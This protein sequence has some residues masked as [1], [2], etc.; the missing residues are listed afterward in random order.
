M[1]D[2]RI[3]GQRGAAR[4]ELLPTQLV[5]RTSCGTHQ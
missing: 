1:L 5:V 2:A 3:G 4:H